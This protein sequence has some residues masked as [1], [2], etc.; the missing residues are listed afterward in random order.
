MPGWGPV[1]RRLGRSRWAGALR[2]ACA[3][4]VLAATPSAAADDPDLARDRDPIGVGRAAPLPVSSAGRARVRGDRPERASIHAAWTPPAHDPDRTDRQALAA[5]ERQRLGGAST[6]VE[7]APEAWMKKLAR[8]D[9]PV[10]WNRGTVEYLRYF[11]QD[12]RGKAMMRAWL[13]RAGR[14]EKRMRAILREQ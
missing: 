7:V 4:W 8:P 12:A 5:F 13:R 1:L 3:G 14:Y 2:I 9:L 6:I 10:R 11:T